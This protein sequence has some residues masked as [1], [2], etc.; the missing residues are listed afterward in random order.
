MGGGYDKIKKS[1]ELLENNFYYKMN[2]ICEP[3]LGKRGLYR[4]L[5]NQPRSDMLKIMMHFIAYA[6][7]TNDLIDIADIIGI[8]AE[9][10]F[11]IIDKLEKADLIQIVNYNTLE[12]NNV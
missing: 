12:K 7:G 6:D 1:I 4:T 8:Q 11:E 3:Q 10:L 9:E 2:V 5:T